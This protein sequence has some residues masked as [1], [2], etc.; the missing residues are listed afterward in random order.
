MIG[1]HGE[2]DAHELELGRPRAE[3]KLSRRASDPFKDEPDEFGEFVD[4]GRQ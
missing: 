4:E 1:D 3:S 2:E